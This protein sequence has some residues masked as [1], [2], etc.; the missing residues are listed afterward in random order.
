MFDNIQFASVT[1]FL[2]MGKYTFHVWS[3]YGLFAVFVFVNLFLPRVQRRQFIREQ[4]QK[5]LR[6][7]QL[8]KHTAEDE[9]HDS[10]LGEQK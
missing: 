9:V 6:D 3:V 7:A 10:A 8:A 2:Q 1:E 4:R 5:S